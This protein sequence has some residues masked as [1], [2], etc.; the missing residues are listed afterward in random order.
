MVKREKANY[1]IQSVAHGLEVLEVLAGSNGEVGVTKLS[2]VLNLHKNNVFRLLATLELYGYVEQNKES[3]GYRLGVNVLHLGQSYLEQSPLMLRAAPIVRALSEKI[4]ETVN[5][6]VLQNGY[7][8]FPISVESKRT[9]KVSQRLSTALFAKQCSVGRLLTAQLSDDVL[10]DVLAGNTPQDAA[11]RT[12]MFDLRSTG[13]AV[14]RGVLEIDVVSVSK[15]IRD[16]SSKVVAALEVLVPQ[17]RAKVDECV[18]AVEESAKELTVSLGASVNDPVRSQIE[19]IATQTEG[20]TKIYNQ[21]Q[22]QVN[23]NK[24]FIE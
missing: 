24:N 7:V 13:R 22:V 16:S 15:V 14:D 1:L 3:E 12:Q 10:D 17:Y 2:E 8:Y 4:G 23:L 5:L 11:I 9:V 20:S 18:L 21:S 6:A 19:K